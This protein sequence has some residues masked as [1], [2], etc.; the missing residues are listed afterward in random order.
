MTTQNNTELM[1]TY[2]TLLESNNT[3]AV[4]QETLEEGPMW[5]AMKGVFNSAFG[6][7]LAPKHAPWVQRAMITYI[8]E[9]QI[10]MKQRQQDYDTLTWRTITDFLIRGKSATRLRI[11][12]KVKAA[13]GKKITPDDSKGVPLTRDDISAILKDD[14]QI[15]AI[16]LNKSKIANPMG[17]IP[18]GK[19]IFGTLTNKLVGQNSNNTNPPE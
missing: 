19:A 14:R 8:R 17:Y 4:N 1:R 12:P 2:L 7:I 3:S 6:R 5:D 10:V 16:I 15:I 13:D 9:F 18:R 11:G